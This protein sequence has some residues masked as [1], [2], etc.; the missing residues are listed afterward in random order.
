LKTKD[1]PYFVPLHPPDVNTAETLTEAFLNLAKQTGE[2]LTQP[3]IN[4][5]N[6]KHKIK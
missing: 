1:L 5:L 3:I 2:M 6:I 4:N